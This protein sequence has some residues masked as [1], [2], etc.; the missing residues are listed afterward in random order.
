MLGRQYDERL[1]YR[2]RSNWDLTTHAEI[3]YLVI[4]Y[5]GRRIIEAFA[6]ERLTIL[7]K[8]SHLATE[9]ETTCNF[10]RFAHE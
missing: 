3:R 2:F 6:T 4:R 1:M 10:C 5:R 7:H 8:L 9:P